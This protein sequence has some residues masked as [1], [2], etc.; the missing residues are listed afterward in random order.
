LQQTQREL[1]QA[2]KLAS[3]GSMVAGISHEL[4]TPLGI[5]VTV[6][7]SV[8]DR[9]HHLQDQFEQGKLKRSSPQQGMAELH[10]PGQC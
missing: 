9:L 4:D 1:V 6:L 5:S 7:S 10:D 3:L 8:S 2:A